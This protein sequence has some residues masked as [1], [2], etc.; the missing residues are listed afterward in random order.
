MLHS[1]PYM[2]RQVNLSKIYHQN[3]VLAG[4]IVAMSS[5]FALGVDVAG[6]LRAPDK[7]LPFF[8]MLLP[9]LLITVAGL[10]VAVKVGR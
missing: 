5:G 6:M 10:H 1:P 9:I 8:G 7:A 4:R 3:A 2:E